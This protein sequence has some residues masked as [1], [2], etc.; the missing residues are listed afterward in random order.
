MKFVFKLSTLYK[1][2]CIEKDDD[3]RYILNY[4]EFGALIIIRQICPVCYKHFRPLRLNHK[5]CCEY[6]KKKAK[7]SRELKKHL[8]EFMK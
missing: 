7:R 2:G 8:M 4:D 5:Y 6:C 1:M 3:N